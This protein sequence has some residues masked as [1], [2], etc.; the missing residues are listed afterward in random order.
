MNNILYAVLELK[1]FLL[2]TMGAAA[3]LGVFVFFVMGRKRQKLNRY[4]IQMLVF[5]LTHRELCCLAL[6]IS[7]ICLMLSLLIAG[8]AFGVVQA[9]ALLCVC[10]M[11]GVLGLSVAGAFGDVVYT[12]FMGAALSVAALL[13]DYIRETG[14]D[15]YI[16]A[17]WILL[18]LFILQY[19]I[20][21][22]LK[23]TERML[24][25]HEQKNKA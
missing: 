17:I 11:K 25:K 24:Y 19:S 15:F 16:G 3:L 10:V 5:G 22:F 14:M 8:S 12:A 18:G 20:Y 21:Y 6:N 4:G 9:A 2:M 7:Q 13:R 23:E 1:L